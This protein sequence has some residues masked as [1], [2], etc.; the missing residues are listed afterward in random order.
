M[1]GMVK[2]F[3]AVFQD[4]SGLETSQMEENPQS[5]KK[6]C[7]DTE[8]GFITKWGFQKF[9]RKSVGLAVLIDCKVVFS[10][11]MNLL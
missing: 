11:T 6:D 7:K 9:P 10:P 8:S 1:P 2:P 3:N 4:F 5:A